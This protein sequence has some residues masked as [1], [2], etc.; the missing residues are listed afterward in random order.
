MGVVVITTTRCIK[1]RCLSSVL[2]ILFLLR[3]S[4]SMMCLSGLAFSFSR[5]LCSN[6]QW[7]CQYIAPCR[8]IFLFVSD[9]SVMASA[10]LH[11]F[12]HYPDVHHLQ[13]SCV[14]YVSQLV[15][16]VLFYLYWCV[17]SVVHIL[18][19]SFSRLCHVPLLP[20]NRCLRIQKWENHQLWLLCSSYLR[21]SRAF[22][23]EIFLSLS[24][25]RI[26]FVTTDND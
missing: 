14:L 4:S 20:L 10:V 26:A 21:S 11:L 25:A 13:I 8:G 16:L 18:T 6:H 12:C 3:V 22:S 19:R 1:H 9:L 15:L 2:Q 24:T 17:N 5:S 23:F 7:T